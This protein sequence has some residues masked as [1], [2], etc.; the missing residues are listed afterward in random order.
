[1]SIRDTRISSLVLVIGVH[2]TWK[3]DGVIC[4]VA[5]ISYNMVLRRSFALVVDV[6]VTWEDDGAIGAVGQISYSVVLC[7]S[8]ALVAVWSCAVH[9]C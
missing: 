9:W 8:Y 6:R 1:M 7:Y 2:V 4:A 3:D 5:K